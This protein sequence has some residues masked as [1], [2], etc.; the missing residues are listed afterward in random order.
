MDVPLAL[1]DTL[2]LGFRRPSLAIVFG[3]LPPAEESL[4]HVAVPIVD[5]C[6]TR[7]SLGRRC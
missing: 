3:V 1:T 4:R 2:F 7:G 6:C 5:H